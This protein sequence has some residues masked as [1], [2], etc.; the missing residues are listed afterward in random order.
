[1]SKYVNGWRAD[2]YDQKA[3]AYLVDA[4]AE[5]IEPGMTIDRTKSTVL[6]NGGTIPG[7]V[8]DC[9]HHAELYALRAKHRNL[10]LELGRANQKIKRLE[11]KIKKFKD[12][13]IAAMIVAKESNDT[14]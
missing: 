4:F 11:S 9:Q 14:R 1:M 8:F 5:V 6:K 2:S 7:L 12:P 10:A 3:P 13:L